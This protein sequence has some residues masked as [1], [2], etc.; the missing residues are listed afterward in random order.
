MWYRTNELKVMFGATDYETRVKEEET[1]MHYKEGFE[2][3]AEER[4]FNRYTGKE[5]ESNYLDEMVNYQHHP[6]NRV[7][8][9]L[10]L[11]VYMV[12]NGILTKTMEDELY[13]T[14]D[15]LENGI[16]DEL[17]EE[18]LAEIRKDLDYCFNKIK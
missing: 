8:A 3:E 5:L 18:E 1:Y 14:R 4:K 13:G 6:C 15:D 12:K 16:L 11:G 10:P 17:P 2:E 9:V 7:L